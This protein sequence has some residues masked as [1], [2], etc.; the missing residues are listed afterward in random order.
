MRATS[1][2]AGRL[3]D[4]PWDRLADA[5]RRAA[6]HPDG[7]V[8]LSVGTPVDPVGAS[9]QAALAAAANSPGYPTVHG[10]PALREAYVGWLA[11]RHHVHGIDPA[12]VLPTIGSKELVG[13]LPTQLGLTGEDL[14]V[15]PEIGYPTYEVGALMAGTAIARS[16]DVTGFGAGRPALVWLNSPSNPTGRVLGVDQLAA[17]VA[18]AR[19]RGCVVA[20]DEC[21]LDLGWD[22]TPVS[23]LQPEVNG[24]DL[25]GLLAVHSLSKRS[26]LAGYRIG[27][28]SGDPSLVASLLGLRRH[29]GHMVPAPIQAAAV[30]ALDDDEHADAQ[31][32]RYGRR[33][34]QLIGALTAAG[35]DV[36]HSEAGLYLWATRHEPAME[37]V[38]RL[39]GHGILVAPGS[40]Y[41]PAGDQHVRVAF[42]AS[43]ERVASAVSRLR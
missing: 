34:A 14:V 19:D 15:I 4:F 11:R 22:A 12:A 16:D 30:A 21:Y 10:T 41:G 27:F 17:M 5:G 35:F 37:S 1:G 25:T 20:S 8:D 3:P 39:A 26:N 36:G 40:F 32:D 24:G 42:T 28:V 9:V 13:S 18:W 7:L 43:D 6:A 33:R 23:I 2:P 31:R 29:L 38:D